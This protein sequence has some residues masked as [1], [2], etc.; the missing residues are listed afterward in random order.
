MSE[1]TRAKRTKKTNATPSQYIFIF[2][3]LFSTNYERDR[4]VLCV[5]FGD[6]AK[7]LNNA[8]AQKSFE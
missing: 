1:A 3:V 7:E 2:E 5:K 6:F 4:L 8:T